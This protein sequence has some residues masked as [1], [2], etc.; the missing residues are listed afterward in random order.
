V[1][2]GMFMLCETH[3]LQHWNSGNNIGECSKPCWWPFVLVRG[4]WYSRILCDYH[5]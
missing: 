5:F 4:R 2:Y 1:D 3:L